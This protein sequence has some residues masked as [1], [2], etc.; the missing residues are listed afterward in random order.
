MIAPL[1]DLEPGSGTAKPRVVR[2]GRATVTIE[3]PGPFLECRVKAVLEVAAAGSTARLTVWNDEGQTREIANLSSVKRHDAAVDVSDLARGRRRVHVTAEMV[4]PFGDDNAQA[5]FLPGGRSDPPVLEVTAKIGEPLNAV[6]R[7]LG[8]KVDPPRAAPALG[9]RDGA[10]RDAEEAAELVGAG[11]D[12]PGVLTKMRER[13]ARLKFS[14]LPAALPEFEPLVKRLADPLVFDGRG[15][16]DLDVPGWWR[17]L[18]P[19]S[20]KRFA[21]YYALC[22]ARARYLQGGPR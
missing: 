5:M 4:A 22:C 15:A 7:I 13:T 18:A 6:N 1:T 8:V 10:I 3:A 11:D 19:A 16:E 20:R 21:V 2:R 17:K 9:D 12:L 14:G